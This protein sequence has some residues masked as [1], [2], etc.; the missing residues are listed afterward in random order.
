MLLVIIVVVAVVVVAVVVI[1][2]IAITTQILNK[3]RETY[4]TVQ[5]KLGVEMPNDSNKLRIFPNCL[6][7]DTEYDVINVGDSVDHQNNN[8]NSDVEEG[9]RD[10]IENDANCMENGM[11]VRT[12]VCACAGACCVRCV[13]MFYLCVFVCI[14]C[15]Y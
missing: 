6:L 15:I 11:R 13:C 7:H 10:G 14:G 2:N 1:I 12:H 9:F 4:K 3:N 5:V 8:N